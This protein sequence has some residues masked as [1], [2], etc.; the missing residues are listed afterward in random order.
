LSKVART[1]ASRSAAF[2]GDGERT[3]DLPSRSASLTFGPGSPC[4][5]IITFGAGADL[6]V[7]KS[8]IP[9]GLSSKLGGKGKFLRNRRHPKS[10]VGASPDCNCKLAT[11]NGRWTVN[12]LLCAGSL[13]RDSALQHIATDDLISLLLVIVGII[14]E[15]YRG[16]QFRDH[17]FL[18]PVLWVGKPQ[19]A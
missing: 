7:G 3:A 13:P 1:C 16:A 10:G 4:R 19:G 6:G 5:T 18:E 8:A 9:K 14:H 2:R 15:R 12:N 17:Q 11:A